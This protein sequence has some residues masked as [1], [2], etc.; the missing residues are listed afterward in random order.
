MATDPMPAHPRD[1][2]QGV[3]EWNCPNMRSKPGDLDM[4]Y[5]HYECL[6]CGRSYK[7]YYEEM[8]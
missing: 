6:V 3:R 8:R 2:P 1:C 5:E 4:E 7:L